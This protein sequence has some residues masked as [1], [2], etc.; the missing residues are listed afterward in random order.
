MI[1][2]QI[3]IFISYAW[4]NELHNNKVISFCDALRKDFGYEAEM[5][6]L[7]SQQE[8]SIHFPEMMHKGIESSDKVIIVL[9]P[10][11]KDKAETF[12]GGV[13][14]EYRLIITEISK[15]KQKYILISFDGINDEW[16]PFGLKGRNVID[17]SI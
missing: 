15:N 8:S 4:E 10:K 5:D 11:Y 9:S 17:F 6:R 14:E 16:I 12:L 1:K 2:N 7:L 3:K 13:G